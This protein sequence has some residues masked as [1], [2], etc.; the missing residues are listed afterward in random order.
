MEDFTNTVIGDKRAGG[1]GSGIAD[2]IAESFD[3]LSSVLNPPALIGD[4]VSSQSGSDGRIREFRGASNDH[5]DANKMSA[6]DPRA[7][8]W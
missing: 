5:P 7:D 3:G 1:V 6:W 8:I 2:S 4:G